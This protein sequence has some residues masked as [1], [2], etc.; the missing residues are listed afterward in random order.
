VRIFGKLLGLTGNR[1]VL[2][3]RKGGWGL[4]GLEYLILHYWVNGVGG[5]WLTRRGCGTGS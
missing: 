2:Q 3:R 5:C 1:F 4:R